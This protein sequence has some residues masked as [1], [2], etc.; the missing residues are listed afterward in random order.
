MKFNVTI[1]YPSPLIALGSLIFNGT[2]IWVNSVD[3]TEY[4]PYYIYLDSLTVAS[5]RMP[6]TG[7]L[8]YRNSYLDPNEQHTVTVQ[9]AR[10]LE[11]VII[12]T[13]VGDETTIVMSTDDSRYFGRTG[14]VSTGQWNTFACFS[15]GRTAGMCHVSEGSG[16]EI[17]YMFQGDAITIWGA[18]EDQDSLYQVSVDDVRPIS[19]AGSNA[20]M[21]RP[22]A[23]LAHYSNLGS[24]PHT[25]RLM[26]LPRNGRSR[27]EVDYVQIYAKVPLTG[28]S[29]TTVE[30][31]IASS[32]P[33][34]GD[35]PQPQ[36]AGRNLS[37]SAV[38]GIVVGTLLGVL[39]LIGLL[40]VIK[41]RQ[42][43]KLLAAERRRE[44]YVAAAAV[45]GVR[46]DFDAR[47]SRDFDEAT[48]A[49][50][51]FSVEDGQELSMIESRTETKRLE[52]AAK[53]R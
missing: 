26:S 36:A 15:E 17:S 33:L 11:S 39:A 5:V 25:I 2:S 6:S 14:F 41:L 42:K 44:A 45:A 51:K 7:S 12:E 38:I 34:I 24:G 1:A 53:D 32:T 31:S 40:S 3:E 21:P 48:L 52:E 9:P 23:V 47:G 10:L 4:V 50:S 20:T 19:F 16:S 43:K 49:S 46:V 28:S 13:D 30:P 18:V 29:P 37:K 22:A 8:L 27:I 35:A